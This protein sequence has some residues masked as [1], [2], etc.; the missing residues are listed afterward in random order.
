MISLQLF[1]V[2]FFV[3]AA[4]SVAYSWP[5]VEY[6]SVRGTGIVFVLVFQIFACH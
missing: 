6:E 3:T 4:T 5:V 2:V 1:L